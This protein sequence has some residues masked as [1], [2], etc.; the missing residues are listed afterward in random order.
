M[1]GVLEPSFT[2]GKTEY[3][4]TLGNADGMLSFEISTE[5]RFAKV[6]GHEEA[7]VPNGES[8]R[9]ITVT[10]EDGSI[11]VYT[12]NVNRIRT[13]NAKLKRLEVKGVSIEEEFNQDK[14][15]YTLYV[16]ND[17][18]TL[19]KD[20]IIAEPLYDTTKVF[21]DLSV[22]LLVINPNRYEIKTIAEDG[23]TTQSYIIN[24]IRQKSCDSTLKQ[25]GV[26]GYEIEPIFEREILEYKVVIPNDGII[27]KKE[28]VLAI[29]TDEYAK[30]EK[31]ENINDETGNTEYL[32]KV[33]SHDETSHT[34]YKITLEIEQQARIIGNIITENF[35]NKHSANISLYKGEEL[36]KEVKT[37]ENGSYEL[38]VLPDIYKLVIKKEG[39]LNYTVENIVVADIEDEKNI[40]DYHLIAGD[41]VETGEIEI[42][43]L[44]ALND[45][46]GIS[47]SH[48][49]EQKSKYIKYDLNE[50][51][52]IDILDKQILKQNYSKKTQTAVMP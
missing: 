44:V 2:Y 18:R 40:G 14:Y 4:L 34:I 46:I 11:K 17:K 5:D 24:V 38:Q 47:V 51:G 27:P 37:N 36:I 43:D 25:L 12:I 28:D 19:T 42:D 50:D 13:D 26:S 22:S 29:P 6:T 41:V 15:E 30:V 33:T 9:I 10:A 52:I 21:P 49:E 3:N 20:E 1:H 35:Q 31:E 45:H 7:I 32:I 39:Y 23:Y 8:Q 16:P 48:E